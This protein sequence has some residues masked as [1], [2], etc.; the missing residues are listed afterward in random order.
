MVF[1]WMP[2]SSFPSLFIVLTSNNG[3]LGSIYRVDVVLQAR[4]PSE[5][6]VKVDIEAIHKREMDI[7]TTKLKKVLLMKY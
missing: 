4:I 2:D 6:Q 1:V 3:K 7:A 5:N